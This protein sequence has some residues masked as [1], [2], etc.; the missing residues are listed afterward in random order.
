MRL[1]GFMYSV[2][3][4]QKVALAQGVCKHDRTPSRN[5]LRVV[6]RARGDMHASMLEARSVYLHSNSK[7]HYIRSIRP[8]PLSAACANVKTPLS[9]KTEKFLVMEL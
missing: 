2:V 7:Y 8:P 4:S 6:H 3:R 9:L 1:F 5:E